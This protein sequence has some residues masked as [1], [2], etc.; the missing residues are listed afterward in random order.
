M[1]LRLIKS[2]VILFLFVVRSVANQQADIKFYTQTDHNQVSVNEEFE[3][4]FVIENVTPEQFTP[5]SFD[6][7]EILA[8]PNQSMMAQSLNGVWKRMTTYSFILRTKNIGKFSIGAAKVIYKGK[9]FLTSPYVIVVNKGFAHSPNAHQNTIQPPSSNNDLVFLTAE[10]SSENSNIYVGQQIIVDYKIYTQV[11]VQKCEFIDESNYSGFYKEE[12]KRFDTR[13]EEKN[14][15]GKKYVSRILKRVALFPQHSGKYLIPSISCQVLMNESKP[16]RFFPFPEYKVLKLSTN[17][18]NIDVKELP[19]PIPDNFCGAVGNFSASISTASQQIT[20]D[21]L[22]SIQ[23]QVVGDGDIKRV[24]MQAANISTDLPSE[25]VQNKIVGEEFYDGGGFMR[26]ERKVDMVLV[27]KDTGVVN[28]VPNFCYFDAAQNK[29]VNLKLDPLRIRVLKGNADKSNAAASAKKQSLDVAPVMTKF[30]NSTPFFKEFFLSSTYWIL[31]LIPILITILGLSYRYKEQ[32]RENLSESVR[33]LSEAA[34]VANKRLKLS[35]KFLHDG[36]VNNFCSEISKALA[37][38][39][40]DK[41]GIQAFQLSRDDTFTQ[42]QQKIG[43]QSTIQDAK[44]LMNLC[45]NV[46]YAGKKIEKKELEKIYKM[47]ANIIHSFEKIK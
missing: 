2:I 42:L 20:T 30:Y 23:W 34:S 6:G 43:E 12:I 22:L 46:L 26:G 24:N 11:D 1:T 37:G 21:D 36:E 3:I 19:T 32:R 8:G 10:L 4:K 17:E 28:I 45:D 35:R 38:Y 9:S 7:F 31:F 14:I 40:T 44:S 41:F 29:Y 39:I 18:L 33:K 15:K 25:V 13:F 5:P 47:S 16:N 27:V